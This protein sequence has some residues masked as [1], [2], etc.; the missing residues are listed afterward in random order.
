[1]LSSAL[2]Q[3]HYHLEK[4]ASSQGKVLLYLGKSQ[5]LPLKYLLC[6]KSYESLIL[7]MWVQY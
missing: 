6:F 4:L 1:M 3:D 5:N 2:L 7:I